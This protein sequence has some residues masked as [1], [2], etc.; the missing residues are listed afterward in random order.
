ML[1]MKGGRHIDCFF[2]IIVELE[3]A[4]AR[5]RVDTLEASL[6]VIKFIYDIFLFF[7]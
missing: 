2:I 6:E 1:N 7:F 3:I 5:T 4:A